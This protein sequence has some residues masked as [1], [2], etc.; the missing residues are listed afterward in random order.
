LYKDLKPIIGIEQLTT[1]PIGYFQLHTAAASSPVAQ[2]VRMNAAKSIFQGEAGIKSN[3]PQSL[4]QFISE[5]Q[6]ETADIKYRLRI[7]ATVH[8]ENGMYLLRQFQGAGLIKMIAGDMH[9]NI[10]VR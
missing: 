1:Q 9:L 7:A 8:G 4:N 2:I 6:I 3:R 10:I 5:C